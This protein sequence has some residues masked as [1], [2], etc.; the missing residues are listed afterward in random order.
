MSTPLPTSNPSRKK[1]LRRQIPESLLARLW[2]ERAVRQQ[3]LKTTEGR[4]VRILYPGRRG[5]EAGPDFR[6]AL[7]S[8]SY[9]H[10]TLPTKRIV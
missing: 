3:N 5:T 1:A 7:I 2:R 6:D 9:T 10:L 8:V 4:H